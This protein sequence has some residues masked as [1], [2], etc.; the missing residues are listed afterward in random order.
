MLSS[1]PFGFISD[2]HCPHFGECSSLILS[3]SF[4]FAI[5]NFVNIHDD[6]NNDVGD[7]LD[8][9]NMKNKGSHHLKIYK[10]L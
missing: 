7:G 10:N 8:D 4:L 2:E 5:E 1:N 9:V 3:Q 6:N